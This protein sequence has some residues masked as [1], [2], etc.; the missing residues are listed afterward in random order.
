VNR[1]LRFTLLG[2][3]VVVVATACGDSKKPKTLE[4][5][6]SSLCSAFAE[7][8]TAMETASERVSRLHP[9]PSEAVSAIDA[10]FF[11]AKEVTAQLVDDLNALELPD[12]ERYASAKKL[13]DAA[14]EGLQ[15]DFPK[16]EQALVEQVAKL[17][18]NPTAAGVG[19][20]LEGLSFFLVGQA[21]AADSVGEVAPLLISDE[22]RQAFADSAKCDRF[23]ESWVTRRAP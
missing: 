4:E 14:L 21:I 7:Y 18:Q 15:R 19:R 13:R 16:N 17:R 3:A 2:L 23:T 6:A 22:L 5:W 20:I 8:R 11:R 1:A 9:L 12:T 10:E